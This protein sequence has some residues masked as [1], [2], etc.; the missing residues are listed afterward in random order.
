MKV[1]TRLGQVLVLS[2]LIPL[3]FAPT[4]SASPFACAD[5]QSACEWCCNDAFVCCVT[6]G[7]TAVS[8]CTYSEGYCRVPGCMNAPAGWPN[9]TPC[10]G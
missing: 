7:G 10:V 1:L 4:A 8:D 6:C 9:C 3:A 5:S 2:V